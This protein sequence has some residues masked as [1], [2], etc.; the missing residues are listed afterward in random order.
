[1]WRRAVLLAAFLAPQAV[2]ADVLTFGIYPTSNPADSVS[3]R[4]E[5]KSGQ[6]NVVEV[7]GAGMPPKS[8]WRWPVRRPE[9]KVILSALQA[10]ISGD[11]PGVDRYNARVPPAPYF[12]VTWSTRVDDVPVSGL[13]IQEGLDMPDLL[14]QLIDTVMPGSGCGSA[15]D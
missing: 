4:I 3:C 13:Y 7:R 15:A 14:S 1:M 6:V 12:T 5:L 11:L 9:E 2:S 8:P 10:L